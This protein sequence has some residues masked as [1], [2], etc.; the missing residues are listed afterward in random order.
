M[1]PCW[2]SH[3]LG[4]VRDMEQQL[5]LIDEAPAD[6]RLDTE[7]REIGLNGVRSARQALRS[8]S[9]DQADPAERKAA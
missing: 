3:P 9:R 5:L 1:C 6:W 7:T 8:T 4:I 2:L